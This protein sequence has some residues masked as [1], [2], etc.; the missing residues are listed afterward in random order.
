MNFYCWQKNFITS[1]LQ[2]KHEIDKA[3]QADYLNRSVSYFKD[4]NVFDIKDFQ[5]S[6]FND[7]EIIKSFRS[8]GSRYSEQH[9]IDIANKFEISSSA[10]K[11][12]AKSFKSVL[13]LDNNFHIYIHGDRK[14]I[15][16]GFDKAVGKRY[17]KIYF[18]QEK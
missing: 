7:R 6:V 11:R 4:N 8:F 12:Q 1:E 17:Y 5:S 14:L 2:D 16:Q 10:V 15:E 9:D 13:K 3:T 18:D